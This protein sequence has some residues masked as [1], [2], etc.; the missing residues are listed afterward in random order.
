MVF[1]AYLGIVRDISIIG[2]EKNIVSTGMALP[3]SLI[4]ISYNYILVIYNK[5]IYLGRKRCKFYL[6]HLLQNMME[7]AKNN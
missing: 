1:V 7:K 6:L 5:Y 4:S 3:L 2:G